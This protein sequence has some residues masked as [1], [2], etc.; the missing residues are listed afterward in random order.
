MGDS[1]FEKYNPVFWSRTKNCWTQ[2]RNE[3]LAHTS[4]VPF[5]QLS[6][7]IDGSWR[8]QFY[9]GIGFDIDTSS[10]PS[11]IGCFCWF[12][13]SELT[14]ERHGGRGSSVVRSV[15]WWLSTELTATVSSTFTFSDAVA[16]PGTRSTRCRRRCRRSASKTSPLRRTRHRRR[17]CRQ[18]S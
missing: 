1:K 14:I 2:S 10:I 9:I 4:L 8:Q 5:V 3:K 7:P 13:S 17:Q 18:K 6:K 12:A 15:S 16:W 11:E